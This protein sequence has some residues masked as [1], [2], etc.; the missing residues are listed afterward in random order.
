M[1]L[2]AALT[3]GLA[4]AIGPTAIAFAISALGLNLQFGYTG[5]LNI[6]HV[7]FMLMGAYGA[8]ITVE[9]GGSL[10]VGILIG[11]LA[12]VVLGLILG[13]PTL[14]LRAEYLA[15]TTI[16][17]AEVLRLVVRSSWAEPLT[18]G[19]F[20]VQ[21]FAGEFFVLNPFDP[22]RVYD[23]GILPINGR[24]LF[25]I[26]VGWLLVVLL[27]LLLARLLNSPWGRLL[28][29]IREDEDAARSLGKNVYARK[30][31]SLTI[32]GAL[33]AVAGVVLAIEQQN[34]VPDS[35]RPEI[36]FIIFAIVILGGAGTI[37]GPVVG[38][39]TF[40]FLFFF[41]D[42]LMR[43][44]QA[45]VPFVDEVLTAAGAAQIRFVLLG[46]GIIL[47]LVYRPQGLIGNR[48]EAV[49]GA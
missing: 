20:G 49:I 21:G 44:A 41:L 43:Q 15:I 24:R 29:A 34:V 8:A 36:T 4:A 38:A 42:R 37:W 19:V 9:N 1:D 12:A 46:I 16:A 47:L 10:W 23:F 48:R 18:G 14:R 40:Q 28:R 45:N 2:Q 6:G 7:A 31:Q 35:F 17:A 5:L 39:V 27:T 13:I 26:V 33:G 3:A 32:G 30:L 11:I 25:I 22:G